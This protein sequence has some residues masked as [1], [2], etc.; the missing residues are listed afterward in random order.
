MVLNGVKQNKNYTAEQQLFISAESTKAATEGKDFPEAKGSFVY[1]A[2]PGKV[3]APS[4][5]SGK[6]LIVL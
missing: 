6:N 4:G 3:K 2:A 1:F 5:L